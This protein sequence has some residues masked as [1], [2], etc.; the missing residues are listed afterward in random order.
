MPEF[1]LFKEYLEVKGLATARHFKLPIDELLLLFTDL[2]LTL[3][4][5]AIEEQR[6]GLRNR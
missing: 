4:E 1:R 6:P 5:P 2:P 3:A